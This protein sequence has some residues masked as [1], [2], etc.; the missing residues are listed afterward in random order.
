MIKQI[1]NSFSA[2]ILHWSFFKIMANSKYPKNNDKKSKITYLT[3]KV[4]N[5]V[6]MINKVS[7]DG[8]E[9][10]APG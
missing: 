1:N 3:I 10:T 8:M 7:R 6:S 4:K 2:S 5:K 9:K